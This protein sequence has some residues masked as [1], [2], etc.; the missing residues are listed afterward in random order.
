MTQAEIME[1]L[2]DLAREASLEVKLVGG[3]GEGL[4]GPATSAVCRVK[5]RTWV[6][7]SRTDPA[8]AQ[9]RVLADALR[10][11][12]PELIENRYLPPAVREQILG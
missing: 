2:L 6:V 5:G 10:T 3:L 8:D 1:A 7:L 12:A 4:E 9:L 11:F